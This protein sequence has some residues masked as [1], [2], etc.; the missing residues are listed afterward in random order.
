MSDSQFLL[1]C[2]DQSCV[3]YLCPGSEGA[4]LYPLNCINWKLG[5]VFLAEVNIRHDASVLSALPS[6]CAIVFPSSA[7]QI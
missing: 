3:K 7:T 4:F 1:S 5:A 2:L 6:N